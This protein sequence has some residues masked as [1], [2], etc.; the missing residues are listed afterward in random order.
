MAIRRFQLQ[1][2]LPLRTTRRSQRGGYLSDAWIMLDA[3]DTCEM[4]PAGLGYGT[5]SLTVFV[6]DVERLI[7]A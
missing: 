6:S 5:Q 4:T 2:A 3:A 1:R 7:P